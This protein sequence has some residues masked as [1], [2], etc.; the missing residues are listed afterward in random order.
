MK[1]F[2]RRLRQLEGQL[3]LLNK[4][5]KD[6]HLRHP[7]EQQAR[8]I[9]SPA[10]RK[11]I[12]AGRRSGKTVGAAIMAVMIFLAGHRVLYATPTAEQVDKFWFEV[13]RA[14]AE[15]IDAGIYYKNETLH[16]IEIEGTENRIKAKTAWN[17]DTLRGDY[18]DLL[19]LDEWQLMDEDAWS[20]VGVPMLLDNNGDAVFIY[21]PPSLHSRS[22]SKARDPRHAAKMFKRAEEDTSGRWQAFHFTSHDNPYISIEALREITKDMTGLSY[23]QEILGEDINEVLGA[24]WT[25]ELI[26][27]SRIIHCPDL[28][29]VVI[30]VDPPGGVAECGIVV[31]GIDNNGHGYVLEDCSLRASPDAWAG[32]VLTAYNHNNADRVLGEANFG[33][34]MVEATIMQAAKSRGQFV[35]YKN[36]HASRGKAVR[37]E[38]VVAI[39]EQGRIHHVGELPYLEDELCTWI[40][41][42]SRESPNRMDALVW[43]ITELM[44]GEQEPEEVIVIFDALKEFRVLE[45]LDI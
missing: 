15:F 37:A 14:L 36:V 8:F 25:R 44:L 18:A 34:D 4:G 28:A 13:K 23:R 12:R 5:I 27:K 1:D 35:S 3:L 32:T 9:T 42:E 33:G 29:R 22:V 31:A 45:E 17:A 16:I 19:V 40:P 10:K 43:A 38:P 20:V 6:V 39:Y 21:T 24:L 41:G 26:D 30:G 7:H 11:V 2:S